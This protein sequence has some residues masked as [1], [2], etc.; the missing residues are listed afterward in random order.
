MTDSGPAVG[1]PEGVVVLGM[2][3]SG[4]SLIT[5]LL[6]LLG[7]AVCRDED[8]LVGRAR[9]PRGHWESKSLLRY[10]DR[11]LGEL[12]GS[13]FCPPTLA[14]DETSRLLEHRSE[15]LAA[16]HSAHPERPWVWKDPRTSVLM[17]FWA[18]VLGRR[19]AYVLIVRHP[20]EVSDS[21]ARRNGFTPLF[22]LALWERYTRAAML[23][24]AGRPVMVCTY[25]GVLADPV[26]WCERVVA[27]LRELGLSGL[28]LDRMAIDAFVMNDL[29]HTHEAWSDLQAGEL[30]SAEQV[31]LAY[32]ASEY[33][34]QPAYVPPALPAETPSTASVF[35]QIAASGSREQD[36]SRLPA[37]LVTP[38]T[39]TA[40]ARGVSASVSVVLAQSGPEAVESSIAALGDTL[41]SGSELL[42]TGPVP[43]SLE[44]LAHPRELTLCQLDDGACSSEAETLSLGAQAA[45]GRMVV[46]AGGGLMRCDPWHAPF[47]RALDVGEVGAVAPLLRTKS[48]SGER[49]L[50]C[51]FADEDLV[52][53][54]LAGR[55]KKELT[56][57]ALLADAHCALKRTVLAAAGGVDPDFISASAAIAELSVRLWRMGFS[58]CIVPQ[59]EAW[60][61]SA[62]DRPP[63][64]SETADQLYERMRIAALH[65]GPERLQAFTER[66]RALPAYAAAAER[67]AATDVQRRR[68]VVNAVCAFGP[69]R[70]FARFPLRALGAGTGAD[71]GAAKLRRL[72]FARRR[73]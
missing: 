68:A 15:A 17:P 49:L 69:E 29:R 21:L 70:Y 51:E 64:G 19:A 26:S 59:V 5:R 13:W 62:E 66:A 72:G 4:T 55:V 47:A 22:G 28:T 6:S 32:A 16:L 71:A 7:L 63:A 14:P 36:L 56:P 44:V 60:T 46:L 12:G 73:R 52:L 38:K 58:C 45:T 39:V 53:S 54:P 40:L 65:L 27:F 48:A 24:A 37:H 2:H 35:A 57:I 1:P 11:L 8:L 34:A 9:N 43:A 31:A 50:G 10:N 30:I 20:F 67:L 61:A 42:F 33:T 41:P 3:R 25:D 23:G 18:A